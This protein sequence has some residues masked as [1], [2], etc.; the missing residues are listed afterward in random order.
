MPHVSRSFLLDYRWLQ[1]VPPP[2]AGNL[3]CSAWV[4]EKQGLLFGPSEQMLS[5]G[6]RHLNDLGSL[7]GLPLSSCPTFPCA[8]NSESGRQQVCL[9]GQGRQ[10]KK[11]IWA[12]GKS[13]DWRTEKWPWV[14][15][16]QR[17]V[18]SFPRTGGQENAALPLLAKERLG[19]G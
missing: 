17:P 8:F 15:Q 6:P 11:Q 1:G 10:V 18:W 12:K 9:K 13:W 3:T 2:C 7:S 4:P 16:D 19:L 5:T 14:Y